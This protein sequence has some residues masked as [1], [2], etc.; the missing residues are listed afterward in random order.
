MPFL[1]RF[2]NVVLIADSDAVNAVPDAVADYSV[3]EIPTSAP[4]DAPTKWF[5]KF[6]TNLA[7]E[8]LNEMKVQAS[9]MLRFAGLT[10]FPDVLKGIR[11]ATS[12]RVLNLLISALSKPNGAVCAAFTPVT[13]TRILRST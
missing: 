2:H 4:T 3:L 13:R 7:E 10:P 9:G 1:R 12:I 6:D 5:P 8:R 11:E